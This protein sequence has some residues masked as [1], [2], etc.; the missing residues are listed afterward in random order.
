M[1]EQVTTQTFSK[2]AADYCAF[3]EDHCAY[4]AKQ[5][6]AQC[7]TFLTAINRAIPELPEVRVA[8]VTNPDPGPT[9][10]ITRNIAE[11]LGDQ[12][13]NVDTLSGDLTQIYRYLKPGLLIFSTDSAS[14]VAYWKSHFAKDCR[15]NLE[16]AQLEL[17]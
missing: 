16:R 15:A 11:K 2:L 8:D 7:T 3:L 6:T 5:F 17:D 4:S 10:W 13:S 12:S 9:Q 14:A 1:I